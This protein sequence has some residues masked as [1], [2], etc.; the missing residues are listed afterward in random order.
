MIAAKESLADIDYLQANVKAIVAGRERLSKEL[1]KQGILSPLPSEANFILCRVLKG[2]AREIKEAL[3]IEGIFIRYFD[4]PL[5][6]NMLRI[7]VG[8]PEHT[9]AL[10]EALAKCEGE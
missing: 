2:N 3:E 10:I 4:T 1:E 9:D 8:K 7:S 5:L 6:N